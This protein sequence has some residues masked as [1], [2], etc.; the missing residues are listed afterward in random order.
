[1]NHKLFIVN[2]IGLMLLITCSDSWAQ[3]GR[4]RGAGGFGISTILNELDKNRNGLLDVSEANGRTRRLIE[5]AGLNPNRSHSIAS[6]AKALE[7][8]NATDKN[9]EGTSSSKNSKEGSN[10]ARKVP[11]FGVDY[12]VQGVSDFSPSGEERMSVEVMQSR[13]GKSVM[14]QV[15]RT[16]SRYDTDKNGILDPIEQ[17]KTRWSNPSAEESDT[18]KDGNLTRLEMAY[19]YQKRE[20]DSKNRIDSRR[21]RTSSAS[22]AL[23]KSSTSSRSSAWRSR[24]TTG[25][26]GNSKS[27]K[28]ASNTSNSGKKG[29]DPRKYADGIMREYDKNKDGRLDKEELSEMRRPPHKADTNKDGFVSKAEMRYWYAKDSEKS[30]SGASS[31]SRVLDSKRRQAGKE[32]SNKSSSTF[33]DKDT[34]NDGQLQMSE[35]TK[36]WT[37]ILV[38]EFNK[39]DLNGDGILTVSEWEK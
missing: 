22:K 37:Q 7:Q 38:D 10:T 1:M 25:R 8:Q 34:N 23:E 31:G 12:E 39:K 11:G 17:Q 15:D 27:T 5:R 6:V 9:G 19:R 4:S 24:Q 21:N 18:N 16:F 2:L 36:A 13:F 29:F 35:Y 28:S 14:D 26:F 20:T 30:S 33:G 3:L 32:Y